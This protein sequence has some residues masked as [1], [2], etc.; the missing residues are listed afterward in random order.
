MKRSLIITAI[1]LYAILLY[2]QR[3]H[4][5]AWRLS[6]LVLAEYHTEQEIV[7]AAREMIYKNTI[8]LPLGDNDQRT[9][10]DQNVILQGIYKTIKGGAP[11]AT[12]CGP[13]ARAM[14]S[15]LER[16]DF[17]TRIIHVFS[18]DY[19]SIQSHTFLEAKI[20]G[21]WQVHD[22]DF[23]IYYLKSNGDR[24]NARDVLD[25]NATPVGGWDTYGG[26]GIT[27]HSYFE[28]LMYDSRPDASPMIINQ[29]RFDVNKF[30]PENRQTF[31]E[32][33]EVYG[34]LKWQ[35]SANLSR[36]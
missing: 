35:N 20:N 7:D 9:T 19:Q 8:H 14:R 13:R 23:N 17:E 4:Y 30:F 10:S 24:A 5:Y 28:A 33:S 3:S 2:G 26:N 36:R 21:A 15:I 29:G 11:I 31:F 16:L 25:G 22:P 27:L 1:L 34:H 18:D 32:F 6:R 12:T